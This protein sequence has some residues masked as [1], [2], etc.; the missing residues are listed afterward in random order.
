MYQS[1]FDT[2]DGRWVL[3]DLMKKH[4]YFDMK[5]IPGDEI[6]NAFKNGERSVVMFIFKTVQTNFIEQLE[7]L[8]KLPKELYE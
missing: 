2:E 4:H 7:L 8:E 3:Q 5:P 1:V 6:S